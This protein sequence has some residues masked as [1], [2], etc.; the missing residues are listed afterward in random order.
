MTL[1]NAEPGWEHY[2][3]RNELS[4]PAQVLDVVFA[5]RP[6]EL[7]PEVLDTPRGVFLIQTED[8]KVKSD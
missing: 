2:V 1:P 5:S 3:R 7:H 4:V 8:R 6:G